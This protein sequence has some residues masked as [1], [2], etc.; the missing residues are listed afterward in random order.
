VNSTSRI[1]EG[2]EGCRGLV[3]G[4]EGI[5]VLRPAA[6]VVVHAQDLKHVHIIPNP[7][8]QN[9]CAHSR[10]PR[11]MIRQGWST[12]LFHAAQQ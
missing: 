1:L 11:D 8:D 6:G 7:V 5:E 3:E 10:N 9:W 12:S 4:R 2:L